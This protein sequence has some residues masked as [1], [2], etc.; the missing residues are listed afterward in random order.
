MAWSRVAGLDELDDPV[1]SPYI[2]NSPEDDQDA[3]LAEVFAAERP[4]RP[5]VAGAPVAVL[6]GN[7]TAAGGEQALVAFLGRPETRVFGAPTAGMP[8]VAPNVHLADGAV[9]RVPTWVPVDRDGTR[10]TENIVPDEVIGDTRAGSSDAI[11]DAATEWLEGQP[12]CS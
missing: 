9:F 4:H 8:V 5:S 10:Y 2:Q 12:G 1:D 7:G 11:L 3:E 6:V